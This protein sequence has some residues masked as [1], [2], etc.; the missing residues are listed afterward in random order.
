M[1]TPV[2]CG[3]TGVGVGSAVSS[4][5]TKNSKI[6]SRIQDILLTMVSPDAPSLLKISLL[7]NTV[8]VQGGHVMGTLVAKNTG[9]CLSK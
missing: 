4:Q 6:A 7:P 9:L 8:Y 5:A 3:G 1:A 2:G